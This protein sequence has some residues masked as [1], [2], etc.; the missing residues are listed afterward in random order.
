VV[1][2]VC[3]LA[4]HQGVS[5]S[6]IG[7]MTVFPC[8]GLA[9]ASNSTLSYGLLGP[10]SGLSRLTNPALISFY[11]SIGETLMERIFFRAHRL[12]TKPHILAFV[13]DPDFHDLCM[14]A[15]IA[16]LVVLCLARAFP[17]DDGTISM[18]ALLS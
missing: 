8:G 1:I 17:L 12:V 13:A 14:F 4:A 5:P 15:L 9:S 7:L 18:V 2:A 16:L 10:R 6:D 3:A 11:P